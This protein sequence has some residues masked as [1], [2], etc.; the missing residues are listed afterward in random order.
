M[1]N[2]FKTLFK[3]YVVPQPA[4]SPTG[5][6]E[7]DGYPVDGGQKGTPYGMKEVTTAKLDGDPGIGGTATVKGIAT[8][9]VR[10]D[11]KPLR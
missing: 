8:S 3:D 5:G 1:P 6:G 10:K 7:T 9:T 11:L 2:A 4:P